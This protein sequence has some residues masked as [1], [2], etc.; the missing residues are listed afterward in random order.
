MT[1]FETIC[2][3]ATGEG[4]AIGIIRISGPNSIIYTSQIFRTK[5]K[6]PITDK[7]GMSISFGF[8]HDANDNII[9]EV[10]VSLF[11][12]PHSY[13]GEDC[14]EISCHNSPY[15]L[16]RVLELLIEQ[17]CRMAGPGEYTKRAFLNGKMDLSQAE[18]V[19]DLIA[20]TSA[21]AHRLAIS[22]MKGQFS[23][24]LKL[25][26]NQI[27]HIASLMELELDFS[28][29]EEIEF[30]D[31]TELMQLA[32]QIKERIT[33]LT[34]SF[35]TGNAIKKG[36]PVAIIGKTNV[37]KST[38]LNTLVGEDKA[39]VSNING[40]TRDAIED[41]MVLQGILFRFIDTAGIRETNDQ[42]EQLGI[43]KTFEKI[44]QA[45]IVLWLIDATQINDTLKT[46]YQQ[47]ASSVKNKKLLIV[48]NKSDLI[49]E[50]MANAQQKYLN[51]YPY[52]IIYISAKEKQGIKELEQAII[53]LSQVSSHW[54]EGVIVSNLRHYE[55]LCLALKSIHRIIEGLSTNIPTDFITQDLRDCIYH[56]NDIIGEVT[57]S[58]IIQN[59]FKSFCIGK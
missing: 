52:P 43:L 25:L 12:A 32:V 17:G 20:S 46:E 51:E 30:A 53:S 21:A 2:A 34:E 31:R 19:A 35:Q 54:D 15:I 55:A 50:D 13:T 5:G 4:G 58:A 8:I 29:H 6:T 57:S 42:I 44:E 11:R 33:Q 39:I 56:L 10:L 49:H 47:I 9:D 41:T 36:I 24:E 28:D 38:L 37:G 48:V 40:T 45:N 18:S 23:M 59:I 27:L 26:R 22:Q 16:Q 1:A 14:I 3:I 7:P